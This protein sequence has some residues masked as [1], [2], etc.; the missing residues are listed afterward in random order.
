[1][2]LIESHRVVRCEITGGP[3][4]N[5]RTFFPVNDSYLFDCGNV[6]KDA[7]TALLQLKRFGMA[8]EFDLSDSIHGRCVYDTER[9]IAVSYIDAPSSNIVAN[10]VS[11]IGEFDG[12]HALEGG[13]DKHVACA[14]LSVGDEEFVEFRNKPNALWLIQSAYTLA[15][16]T[17]SKVHHLYGI[18]AKR[19]DEKSLAFEIHGEVI[20]PTFDIWQRDRLHH[21]QRRRFF[22]LHVK[23]YSS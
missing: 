19:S 2:C 5:H 7:R 6:Y 3:C 14:T 20:N 23:S 15:P 18:V 12:L 16:L 17:R 21:P 11:V 10:I 4:R 1:M 13:T 9:A 8:F 22:C